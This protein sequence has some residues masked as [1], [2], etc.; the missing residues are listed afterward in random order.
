MDVV[1][2]RAL[3]RC[4]CRRCQTLARQLDALIPTPSHIA[5]YVAMGGA[6]VLSAVLAAATIGWETPRLYGMALFVGIVWAL[7]LVGAIAWGGSRLVAPDPLAW[8]RWQRWTGR[9]TW[10]GWLWLNVAVWTGW[11]VLQ[12]VT[13]APL[14]FLLIAPAILGFQL[15]AARVASRRESDV[16]ARRPSRT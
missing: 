10:P 13:G 15:V 3:D 9:E 8:S 4:D 7:C 5:A 14:W 16:C 1:L 12:L 11:V 6:L 2:E